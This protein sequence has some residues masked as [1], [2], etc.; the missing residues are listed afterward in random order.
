MFPDTVVTS[1]RS[2]S[3]ALAPRPTGRIVNQLL[4]AN[5]TA[6]LL[7]YKRSRTLDPASQGM[8]GHI[9]S[10]ADRHMLSP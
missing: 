1:F 10:V 5:S 9:G 8:P 4:Y 6:W 3:V 2:T 7:G